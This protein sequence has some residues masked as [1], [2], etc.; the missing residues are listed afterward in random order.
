MF[1]A[2]P[3]KMLARVLIFAGLIL[4]AISVIADLIVV[5]VTGK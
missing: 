4:L 2:P 1:P 5:A 3:M